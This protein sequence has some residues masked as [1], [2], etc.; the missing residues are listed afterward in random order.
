MRI[1]KLQ[2]SFKLF[3]LIFYLS[4]NLF[5]AQ[6][7]FDAGFGKNGIVFPEIN[8]QV[9][10]AWSLSLQKDNKIILTGW[11]YSDEES[12]SDI[13]LVRL[14]ENGETDSS[15]NPDG[16]FSIGSSTWEDALASAVQEDGKILIA[17][18][19]YNGRSWDFLIVRFNEDGSIDSSFRHRGYITKDFGKDDRAFDIAV[20]NDGKILVCGFAERFNWDF[21]VSRFNQDGSIDT[22]FGEKGSLLLNI[23]TYN[24]VAFSIKVQKDKKIIVCGWTYIFGSWD[25]AIVR[26]NPDGSLDKTFGSTGIVTTDYYSQYNTAH[27]VAIRSDGKYVAAGYTEKLGY[28][29]TDIMLVRYNTD[30]TIDHS[31]GDNG[32]V[33]ADY[34]NADDFAWVVKFDKYDK[35]VVGGNT[36][37]NNSKILQVARFNSDGSPDISF[38]ENGILVTQIAGFDEECRDLLIQSDGKILL[39]GYYTDRE[40]TKTFVIR[41]TNPYNYINSTPEILSNNFPNPF[42]SSTKIIYTIPEY[43]ISENQRVVHVMIKVYDLLGREIETLVD[44]DQEPGI[45]EVIFASQNNSI[46]LSSGIYFYRIQVGS[47]SFV[48]KMMLIR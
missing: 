45:Y 33:L 42:N 3:L 28:S 10:G 35:L 2:V 4:S 41:L 44:D 13:S 5:F 6:S 24:D 12:P 18:R 22:T 11:A 15:F 32:I 30:G 40:S 1:I 7:F 47:I 48:K 16:L 37:I 36:T 29:D 17:G 31:F 46:E 14:F 19:Y 25:F 21:A 8:A 43:L 23:G 39:T 9:N 26:L 20:Q 38:G 27:S 34:E